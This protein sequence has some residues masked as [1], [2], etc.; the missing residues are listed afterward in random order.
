MSFLLGP[1]GALGHPFWEANHEIPVERKIGDDTVYGF[2]TKWFYA[3]PDF[4]PENPLE[5]VIVWDPGWLRHGQ[6]ESRSIEEMRRLWWYADQKN[7]PLIGVYCDWFS[8]WEKHDMIAGVKNTVL[9]CDAIVTDSAGAAAMRCIPPIRDGKVPIH[10]V[11]EL[12][13]YGRLPKRGGDEELVLRS[14]TRKNRNIDIAHVG[15]PYPDRVVQRPYYLEVVQKFCDERSLTFVNKNKVGAR[16]MEDLYERSRVVFNYALGSM[17][18]CRVYEAAAC[19]AMTVTNASNISRIPEEVGYEYQSPSHLRAILTELFN[20]QWLIE[21]TSAS[22]V[23]WAA[24]H[25]PI[26]TWEKNILEVKE[27]MKLCR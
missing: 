7:V 11:R 4:T 26:P 25:A 27:A 1:V 14:G 16:E 15:A 6:D 23:H 12:L 10:E 18:N 2:G 3:G 9:F 20:N 17:L 13:S 24:R 19:G 5:A 21:S 8:S 22:A